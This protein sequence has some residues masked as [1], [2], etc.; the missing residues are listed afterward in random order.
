MVTRLPKSSVGRRLK[1]SARL[2]LASAVAAASWAAIAQPPRAPAPAEAPQPL[3]PDDQTLAKLAWSTIAAVDDADVTGDYSVLR[4]LCAP[5]FQAANSIAAL[6][7]I[8]RPLRA[9]QIDL[10]NAF[11]VAPSYEFPPAIIQGGVLRM[12]GTFALRP[13]SIAFD[14]LFQYVGARWRIIG[15]AVAPLPAQLPTRH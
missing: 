7:E 12:R 10:G 14:L 11:L 2:F 8:F 5:S 1:T 9:Q 3:L 13:T 15:I 4:A 6:A